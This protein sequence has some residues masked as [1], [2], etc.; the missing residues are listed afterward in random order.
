MLYSLYE[1][2]LLERE[3][4]NAPS[5]EKPEAFEAD[6]ELDRETLKRMTHA[7]WEMVHPLK[8][9]MP[10]AAR[11][12]DGAAVAVGLAA[13]SV[14][15]SNH[16]PKAAL[17]VAVGSS[18]VTAWMLAARI[19]TQIHARLTTFRDAEH[20][21]VCLFKHDILA[22]FERAAAQLRGF[23]LRECTSALRELR[24]I[25]E[26]H[27]ALDVLQ[28]QWR[29]RI[30]DEWRRRN[31]RRTLCVAAALFAIAVAAM[32]WG[33]ADGTAAIDPRA[34]IWPGAQFAVS[35]LI[36]LALGAWGDKL[37]RRVDEA[38]SAPAGVTP[39]ALDP[40][41]HVE[42]WMRQTLVYLESNPFW[43]RRNTEEIAKPPSKP[44]NRDLP[45]SPRD[46]G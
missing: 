21:R 16:L 24:T 43:T 31:E 29:I 33:Y 41:P 9:L 5:A 12:R 36:F 4:M 3:P 22:K 20:A 18:F 30:D 2:T 37:M 25:G 35:V 13:A 44:V 1:W 32:V 23:E 7:W 45:G 38:M 34:W 27:H 17:A 26:V 28:S 39:Q 6:T 19:A 42:R 40:T 15:L 14:A 11:I 10:R 8:A 46:G